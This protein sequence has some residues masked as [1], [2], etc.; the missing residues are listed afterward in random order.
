MIRYARPIPL[1]DGSVGMLLVD[2][3]RALT[4]VVP[5]WV[6][7]QL[8]VWIRRG[9][10][11]AG[12]QPSEEPDPAYPVSCC[13]GACVGVAADDLVA[14]RLHPLSDR[15][16]RSDAIRMSGVRPAEKVAGR[17]QTGTGA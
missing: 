7:D 15:E 13:G 8:Q 16:S 17:H 10:L 14:L 11:A 4:T 3:E 2:V 1:E 9:M 5:L 6:V 12:V